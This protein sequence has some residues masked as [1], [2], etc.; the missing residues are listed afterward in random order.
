MTHHGGGNI[1]TEIAKHANTI[2]KLVQ[3]YPDDEYVA[4]LGVSTLAHTVSRVVDGGPSPNE[5][6]ILKSL[7]M[8]LIIRAVVDTVRKPFLQA[9]SIIDHTIELTTAATLHASESFH[10]YPPAIDFLI[11]G[12]RSKDWVSRCSCLSGLIR[13]HYLG[14]ESDQRG[15]DPHKLIASIE[16][17]VP[18]HLMDVLIDYGEYRSEMFMT[19]TAM[20]E[21]QRAMTTC[22]QT[23]DLYRLGLQ[24]AALILRT[25][26][27]IADGQF[28]SEDPVT[29]KRQKDN[30]GLPFTSYVDALPH[31]A[32]AIRAKGKRDELDFADIL[33]IKFYIMRFRVPDAVVIARKGIERNPQ[34]S[35]FYYTLT[36][37]AD[38][39][40]GLKAA[41]QGMKCKQITP[42]VRFQMMQRAVEHAG[43]MGL[44]IL[45]EEMPDEG[46]QRWEQGIAFLMSALEDA[47][48]YV[49][50]APPD[51]RHMKNIGYW[52]ILLMILTREQL[53]PDL[54]EIRVC[55]IMPGIASLVY[56][57]F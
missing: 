54:C 28:E 30:C 45:Q 8:N 42:F 19:A 31:C 48:T 21:F 55:A 20:A 46:A 36:L 35:Y 25:E 26:F 56:A 4:D 9:R 44:K 1:R 37:A 52:Y 29:G 5:P 24:L 47:K 40:Q 13:L 17:R 38:Y 39:V 50:E 22:L 43:G 12:L 15:L 3:A 16:R 32:R 53:S 23:R 14:A 41:K 51:N 10:Q 2:A 57:P 7:D 33:E 6:K 18:S 34:C 49:A 11:A 27:S